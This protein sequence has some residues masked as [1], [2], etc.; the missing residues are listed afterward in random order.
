SLR[1]RPSDHQS[2]VASSAFN[3]AITS[4]FVSSFAIT[5]SRV[6]SV[7]PASA[8]DALALLDERH[9]RAIDLLAG[10]ACHPIGEDGADRQFD[11]EPRALPPHGI[12][13]YSVPRHPRASMQASNSRF[14][15]V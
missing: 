11:A 8:G 2:L 5:S 6:A 13:D 14:A 10:A 9:Q 1:L 3:P 4:S 12:D 15:S 7:E